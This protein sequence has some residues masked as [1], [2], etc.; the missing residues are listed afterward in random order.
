VAI[1][2]LIFLLPQ[3]CFVFLLCGGA[4]RNKEMLITFKCFLIGEWENLQEEFFL[5]A[6]ALAR[7]FELSASSPT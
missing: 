3:W 5:R 2:H 4:I 6:Q 7:R 1:W